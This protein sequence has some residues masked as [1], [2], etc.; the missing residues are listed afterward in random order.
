MLHLETAILPP[1]MLSTAGYAVYADHVAVEYF[2]PNFDDLKWVARGDYQ[3]FHLKNK[4]QKTL[5]SLYESLQPQVRSG[6]PA[7]PG[8]G[9]LWLP[10]DWWF[11][12]PVVS[13]QA[14]LRRQRNVSPH[15]QQW[16][17]AEQK[18][19]NSFPLLHIPL[20]NMLHPV[21]CITLRALHH[22]KNPNC[23]WSYS[24]NMWVYC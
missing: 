21:K 16:E 9:G 18:S 5:L 15:T 20:L 23:I 10:H 19:V 4:K 17:M 8:M 12:L 1:G 13:V 24:S 3:Q 2:N 11:L 7:V 22:M 6:N 14:A